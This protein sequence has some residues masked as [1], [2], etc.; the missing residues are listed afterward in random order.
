MSKLVF[1]FNIG[2]TLS[3]QE[4]PEAPVTAQYLALEETRILKLSSHSNSTSSGA[5]RE[6]RTAL[7]A[8]Y[9]CSDK[10]STYSSGQRREG[11]SQSTDKQSFNSTE[12]CTDTRM[13]GGVLE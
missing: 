9:Q 3:P 10:D 7:L 12:P 13:G 2:K 11:I 5:V 8:T 1:T 6:N 4:A